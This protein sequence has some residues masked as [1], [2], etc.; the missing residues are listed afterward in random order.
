M[1]S[2]KGTPK[3]RRSYIDS[4]FGLRLR[5]ARER[6]GLNIDAAAKRMKVSKNT[7]YSWEA[8]DR[9]PRDLLKL[10][11]LVG[12]SISELFGEGAA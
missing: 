1:A 2:T 11:R 3:K 6:A 9:T 12:L 8:N 7:F 4:E 5:R 10:A